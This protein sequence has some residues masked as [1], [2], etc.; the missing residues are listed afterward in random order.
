MLSLL[1]FIFMAG[2]SLGTHIYWA[3][4]IFVNACRAQNC[5]VAAIAWNA[6]RKHSENVTWKNFR[7]LKILKMKYDMNKDES[8]KNDIFWW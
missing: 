7:G 8:Y 2:E 3:K 6:W 4:K 5:V 1:A